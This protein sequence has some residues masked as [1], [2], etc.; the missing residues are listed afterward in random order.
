[1]AKQLP[2]VEGLEA[3]SL[4]SVM[5]MTWHS[6][7]AARAEVASSSNE[8]AVV[9]VAAKAATKK[10]HSIKGLWSGRY[11]VKE[12]LGKSKYDLDVEFTT[13]TS[14]YAIGTIWIDNDR[15]SGRWTGATLG[16]GLFEYK[17]RKHG[18]AITLQGQLDGKS[19]VAGGT[20]KVD[21][22]WRYSKGSYSMSKL[23]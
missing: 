9:A 6:H 11:S 7:A 13:V 19:H 15:F 20:L 5:P 1:M 21:W 12:F 14:T 16:N 2:M 22:G 18:D 3:R 4:F 8:R 23:A 17:L 10:P